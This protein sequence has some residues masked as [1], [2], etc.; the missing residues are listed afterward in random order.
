MENW[1]RRFIELAK[2]I[3]TWS[4]DPS[5]KCG[6]VIVG[7]GRQEIAFGYNG[8]PRAVIDKTSR[9]S[10]RNLKYSLV[11]HA[12]LNAILNARFYVDGCSLYCYPIPP[13]PECAK[14]IIQAGIT[15]VYTV[16]D[17]PARP[18]GSDHIGTHPST[19]LMFE[20]ADVSL[21]LI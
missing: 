18:K 15:D 8:F 21:H 6:A 14:A 19:S 12:E 3:S 10:N 4:K 7:P 11:V 20:E 17:P 5:T 16:S 13:C 1:N 9:Y 2:H